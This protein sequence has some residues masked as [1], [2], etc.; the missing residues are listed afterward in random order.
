MRSAQLLERGLVVRRLAEAQVAERRVGLERVHATAFGGSS[1]RS[2]PTT[3][4]GSRRPAE[5]GSKEPST[6]VSRPVVARRRRRAT[7]IG[8]SRSPSS[9]TRS[10]KVPSGPQM[11]FSFEREAEA[12]RRLLRPALEQLLARQA[13]AGRVQLDR[14]TAPSSSARKS[15]RLGP[16]RVEPGPPGRDRTSRKC[17]HTAPLDSPAWRS[18]PK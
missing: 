16:G 13:V 15:S 7:R 9:A 2:R 1:A 17:R 6:S 14:R 8:P 12:R 3:R 10:A 5:R 18:R 11:A 4:G